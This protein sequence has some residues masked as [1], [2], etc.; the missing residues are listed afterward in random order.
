MPARERSND[1]ASSHSSLSD[2]QYTVVLFYTTLCASEPLSACS[3]RLSPDCHSEWDGL[4]VSASGESLLMF[5]DVICVYAGNPVRPCS[6]VRS[7]IR[8]LD[9]LS[10]VGQF[11]MVRRPV[12]GHSVRLPTVCGDRAI[13]CDP[14]SS[15]DLLAGIR[16]PDSPSG[17]ASY[18]GFGLVT[19]EL[20]GPFRD[21]GS[22]SPKFKGAASVLVSGKLGG[23][24]CGGARVGSAGRLRV[25]TV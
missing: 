7:G 6:S 18:V 25:A 8:S 20:S 11:D 21:P 2:V 14:V 4:S 3:A 1:V 9:H 23:G 22:H 19:C 12:V 13:R 16:S 24:P 5:N 10:G 15:L 17:S